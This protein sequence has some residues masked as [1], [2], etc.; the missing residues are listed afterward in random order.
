MSFTITSVLSRH[1]I[2]WSYMQYIKK[3]HTFAVLIS[4]MLNIC[5]FDS[6]ISIFRICIW[7]I[8]V[9]LMCFLPQTFDLQ[10]GCEIL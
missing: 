9:A 1:L 10:A 4:G 7:L 6:K 8:I 5:S 3:L 2:S